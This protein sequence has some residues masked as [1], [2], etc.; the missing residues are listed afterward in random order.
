MFNALKI[1]GYRSIEDSGLVE[2]GPITLLVGRNNSGKSAVLRSVF[3]FQDGSQF[4]QQDIRIGQTQ[5]SVALIYEELPDVV[6]LH[7]NVDDIAAAGP[8]VMIL[9]A[10][11]PGRLTL[12]VKSSVNPNQPVNDFTPL[13]SREPANL[14]FPVLSGRRVPFY[15]QQ[16]SRDQSL[17]VYPQDNNLVSRLQPLTASEFPQAV[18]FRELSKDVLGLNLHVL[19][20]EGSGGNQSIGIQVNRFDSISL[21]TMGAGVSGVLSLLLGLST[22]E[23]KLFLIEEP[24]DDLHPQALKVLLDAIAQASSENQF[25]ISSHSSVVLARLGALPGTVVLHVS[26]DNGLPPT[27]TLTPVRTVAERIAVLQDLGYGLADLELGEG[28]LIFEES[29]AERIVREW[30]APWFAPGLRRLRTLAA[31]GTSRLRPLMEDFREMFLFAHLEHV[32]QNR[33]WVIVDGD[34]SGRKVVA[35]LRASFSAWPADRFAHW[36]RESFELYYP[37]R[38]KEQVDA[39]LRE[40][41]RRKR[42]EA[43]ARLLLELLAWIEKDETQAKAEFEASAAEVIDKLR[44][45]EQQVFS[46]E[47]IM[48]SKWIRTEDRA[49]EESEDR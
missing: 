21:E 29:S 22:A 28:W 24:E 26:N 49:V 40:A 39:A 17:T 13:P 25:L 32:Y 12:T 1:T 33:A 7:G 14:I 27:T 34:A 9:T 19:P 44:H 5:T 41:D 45:I 31:R 10:T 2:L 16:M 6:K 30:L 35:D 23:G 20:A 38:F 43:K 15:Q 48:A 37:Q 4:G 47:H 11:N 3:L 36:E 8:G 42:K 18:K 46:S